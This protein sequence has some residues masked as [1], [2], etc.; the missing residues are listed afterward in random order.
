MDQANT[1]LLV[2]RDVMNQ[3]P[4]ATNIVPSVKASEIVSLTLL[5]EWKV[6]S[7]LLI[8]AKLY[9]DP[10]EQPL[11]DPATNEAV[12][13]ALG[14]M[15][16]DQQLAI[17]NKASDNLTKSMRLMKHLQNLFC[18]A[19]TNLPVILL[20]VAHHTERLRSASA[21][22]S[23]ERRQLAE[24]TKVVFL[25]LIEMLGLWDLHREQANTSFKLLHP[26]LY[27]DLSYALAEAQEAHRDDYAKITQALT[28]RLD[29]QN[30]QAEIKVRPPMP[31]SVYRR[32]EGGA[33]RDAL[34]HQLRFAITVDIETNCDRVTQA[35]AELWQPLE[36]SGWR[37]QQPTVERK[38]K[39]NGYQEIVS[40][41]MYTT[42]TIFKE[43]TSLEVAVCSVAA[44][45]MNSYGVIAARYMYPNTRATPRAWWSNHKAKELISSNQLGSRNPASK[46]YVFS[47]VGQVYR[48]PSG[49]TVIDFAYEVHSAIGN[50]CVGARV[51]GRQV[52]LSDK[53]ACGD[54]VEILRALES[55]GPSDTWLTFA[56]SVKARRAIKHVLHDRT[57]RANEGRA[58]FTHLLLEQ[59]QRHSMTEPREQ[60][61]DEFLGT[62]AKLL[63]FNHPD[64]LLAELYSKHPRVKPKDLVHRFVVHQLLPYIVTDT[65]RELDYPE[66]RVRVLVGKKNGQPV[67]VTPGQPIV[68]KLLRSSN[69]PQREILAIYPK[70]AATKDGQ[71][72]K[73]FIPLTWCFEHVKERKFRL[74]IQAIDSPKLLGRII[75]ILYEYYPHGLYLYKQTAD[76]RPPDNY[77]EVEC[78][79]SC[80][81]FRT[82]ELL[83]DRLMK[84]RYES[85]IIDYAF[86]ELSLAEGA[87]LGSSVMTPNPY[88]LYALYDE[89]LR[90][91]VGRQ[92]DIANIRGILASTNLLVLT[93]TSGA[94]KTSLFRFLRQRVFDHNTPYLPVLVE[95]IT[96]STENAFWL[97][98][99]NKLS[100]AMEWRINTRMQY[101]DLGVMGTPYRAFRALLSKLQDQDVKLQPVLLLDEFSYIDTSWPAKEAQAVIAQL[102][103]LLEEQLVK[104]ILGVH[105]PASTFQDEPLTSYLR[106]AAIEY[107]LGPLNREGAETLITTPLAGVASFTDKAVELLCDITGCHPLYLQYVLVQIYQDFQLGRSRRHVLLDEAEVE[108]MEGKLVENRVL[109]EQLHREAARV[110]LGVVEAVSWAIASARQPATFLEILRAIKKSKIRCDELKLRHALEA[111]VDLRI[112]TRVATQHSLTYTFTVPLFQKWLMYRYPA[113]PTQRRLSTKDLV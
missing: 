68:G 110:Q 44:R 8:A 70:V 34:V 78:S 62:V 107:H 88:T 67:F 4:T 53:L 2:S 26:D 94:G 87:M 60:E 45:P 1:G 19:Y 89:N 109:F 15:E 24:V 90:W 52:E 82:I 105:T 47:P 50:S 84:L 21:E 29:E 80:R 83:K 17:A 108:R 13:W 72:T 56:R 101:Q 28:N 37:L 31:Y 64:W 20:H 93:G 103:E 25:P 61:I 48:L 9:L 6:P 57:P 81:E 3:F 43:N 46:I 12:Q 99:A 39:F 59:L 92:D 85:Y 38:Q 33:S 106:R 51:N 98:L 76:V 86:Y 111:M 14:A 100:D 79:M 42:S 27:A 10:T 91:F 71:K 35:V 63:G 54:V 49:S 30:I 95:G 55:P 66:N 73:G 65:G 7:A 40:R 11:E 18:T 112:F 22:N 97:T 58:R 102:L 96:P 69:D 104:V 113:L 5:Q 74:R 23:A 77:V 32:S 41:H 75:N 16:L 36:E